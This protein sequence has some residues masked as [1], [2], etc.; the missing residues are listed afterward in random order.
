M[1]TVTKTGEWRRARALLAAG[2]VRLKA[3]IAVAMRQE[4]EALRREIVQGLTRQAP[5]G[6][7][8]APPKET[9]LA[10]RRLKGFGGSKSLIV[11]ADLR[12][13]VAAI[14]RGDEAFV[15]VPRT[16]RGKDGQSLTK[17][18]EVQEFGSAPIVIPMTDAMRR[19]VFAVLR[20]AGEPIGS[21]GS[22][23]GRGV[24]VVQ[25]PARPFLR[26]AFEKFKPGAQRRFLARVAALTGMGG[27]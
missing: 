17:I 22:G 1:T 3:A 23:G 11:R 8:I 7:A 6:S 4:A 10:A 19:F 26:P 15:G 18:A 14:V 20:E 13:G 9:T 12:N 27:A 5:G 16:A 21:G 25:V 2:P 24:V